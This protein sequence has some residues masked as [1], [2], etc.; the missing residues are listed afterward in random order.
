MISSV[1]QWQK[2]CDVQTSLLRQCLELEQQPMMLGSEENLATD[3]L[4]EAVLHQLKDL[5]GKHSY[6]FLLNLKLKIILIFS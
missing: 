1:V 3:Q 4:I 2:R 6:K 5:W